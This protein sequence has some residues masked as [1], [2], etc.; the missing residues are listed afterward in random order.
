MSEIS[1]SARSPIPIGEVANLS[2]VRLQEPETHFQLRA[3]RFDL[4]SQGHQLE[5]CLHFMTGLGVAQHKCQDGL[6]PAD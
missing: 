6:A 4:L 3:Q 5:S 2:F 1:A